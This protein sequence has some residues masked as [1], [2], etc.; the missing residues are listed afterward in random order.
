MADNNE[1]HASRKAEI[2]RELRQAASISVETLSHK[3]GVSLATVRR[4][5][6]E[7]EGRGLLRRTD[8]GAVYPAPV[9]RALSA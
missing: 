3:L 7:L 4:D 9:L 5:L 6:H 8:G 2:L 1:K